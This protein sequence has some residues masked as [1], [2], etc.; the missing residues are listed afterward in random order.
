MTLCLKFGESVGDAAGEGHRQATGEAGNG[1]WEKAETPANQV[2]VFSVVS[3]ALS[4]C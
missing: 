1:G 4:L 3:E 2:S